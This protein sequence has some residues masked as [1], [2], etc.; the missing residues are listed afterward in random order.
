[1]TAEE[2]LKIAE[3]IETESIDKKY[4]IANALNISY[5]TGY[6]EALEYALSRKY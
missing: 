1:M 4:K 3:T 2:V 5:H 6:R